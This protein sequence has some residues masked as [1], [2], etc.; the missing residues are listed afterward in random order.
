LVLIPS[1]CGDAIKLGDAH[2]RRQQP[3]ATDRAPIAQGNVRDGE[4]HGEAIDRYLNMPA[5]R[6]APDLGQTIT[7][8]QFAAERSRL[9]FPPFGVMGAASSSHYGAPF[10]SEE[11]P[12]AGKAA[13]YHCGLPIFSAIDLKYSSVICFSKPPCRGSAP[14]S[15]CLP[16]ASLAQRR[17]QKPKIML[18]PSRML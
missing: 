6:F 4:I 10:T 16:Q 12:Q 1:I 2:S 3:P 18:L 9:N 7:L 15:L 14:Q 17:S 13:Q 11:K 8:A 5:A